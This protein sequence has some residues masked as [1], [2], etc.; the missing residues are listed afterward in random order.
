MQDLFFYSAKIFWAMVRPDRL[1]LI[2]LT[3]SL[4]LYYLGNQKAAR[5]LLV[6]LLL[7]AW[8]ISILPIGE[9]LSHPLNSHFATNPA[10][11]DRVDGIIV[12]GGAV[13]IPRGDQWGQLELNKRGERIIHWLNLARK[14]PDAR[15][16]F[17]GGNGTP[18]EQQPSEASFIS[19]LI[20]EQQLDP[21][22]LILEDQSR[23]TAE[24]VAYS[25][26]LVNPR[27]GEKWILITS[28][29]HMPRAVG[30]FCK[31]EWPVIPYPVDH[32][33]TPQIEFE[34]NFDPVAQADNLIWTIYEWA[35]LI[36]YYLTGKIDQLLPGRC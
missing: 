33:S 14:F 25:Y 16:V 31:Q 35:G 12:L 1:F 21:G 5:R 27:V 13:N 23:N 18:F 7:S 24:N 6:V 28:A 4:I 26:R 36:S 3:F 19:E 9:W 34:I 17:T 2:L 20:K 32:N 11:P 22:R 10:L 29:S 15:L 8:I 30:L